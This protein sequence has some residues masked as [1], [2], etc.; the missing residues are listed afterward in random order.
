MKSSF[1]LVAPICLSVFPEKDLVD[2]PND[3]FDGD[4]LTEVDGDC[5]DDNA[6]IGNIGMS[7]E[8]VM[9]LDS[10][11]DRGLVH[12]PKDIRS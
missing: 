10:L 12:D 4:G 7:M 9:A 8:M 2:N 3:D 11:A 5:D 6:D 1:A